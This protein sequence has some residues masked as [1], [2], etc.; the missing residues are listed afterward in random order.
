MKTIIAR[1]GEVKQEIDGEE[2]ELI[3]VNRVSTALKTVGINLLDTA[4]QIRDL[5]GVFY[6]LSAKWDGL[7]RNT[8]RYIA[9]IAAGSR[10]IE[11]APYLSV[12]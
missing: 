11:A 7:D 4:G 5:D 3:D 2:I 12:A 1:F 6:E 10:R 8:Q 9:T